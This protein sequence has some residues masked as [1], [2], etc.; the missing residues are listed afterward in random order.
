LQLFSFFF[1]ISALTIGGGYAMIPVFAD[2]IVKKQWMDE[3]EFYDLFAVG[4]SFPGPMAL[5]TA[6]LFGQRMQG[7]SGAVVAFFGILLPPFGAIVLVSLLF[8]RISEIPF[9][10]GFLA[11]SYGVVLGLVASLL[12]KMIRT[13]KWSIP[14]LLVAL[15]GTVALILLKGYALPVFILLITFAYIGKSKWNF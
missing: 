5:N 2:R 9:V 3:K 8:N 15:V 7:I 10:V 4:Q 1:N 6:V 11:G 13:K 14:E 12:Y